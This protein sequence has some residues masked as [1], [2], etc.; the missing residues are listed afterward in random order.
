[1]AL[2]S[3]SGQAFCVGEVSKVVTGDTVRFPSFE[4]AREGRPFGYWKVGVGSKF[5]QISHAKL[6]DGVHT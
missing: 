6:I 4:R 3:S 2:E 5:S 1:M